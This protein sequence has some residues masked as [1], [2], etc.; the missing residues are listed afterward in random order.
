MAATYPL[1]VRTFTQKRNLLDDVDASHINDIQYEIAATQT[2]LGT[3]PYVDSGSGASFPTV[4]KRMTDIRRG[5]HMHYFSLQQTNTY[6]IPSANDYRALS[7]GYVP[8]TVVDDPFNLSN[9]NGITIQSG[10]IYSIHARS[11]V[12]SGAMLGYRYVHIMRTSQ[13]STTYRSLD[14]GV[15]AVEVKTTS[16]SAGVI[17]CAWQG[18]LNKG[19]KV[20]AALA[21]NNLGLMTGKVAFWD[22]GLRGHQIRQD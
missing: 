19:D 9:G 15:Y 5:N 21:V 3:T 16:T 13:A 2:A 8:F 7:T 12:G 11:L 10:G 4:E 1:A 17:H 14:S 6:W 18:R 22:V 20:T